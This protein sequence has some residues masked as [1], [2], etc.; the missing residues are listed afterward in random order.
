MK[1]GC[2]LKRSTYIQFEETKIPVDHT[3]Q[4]TNVLCIPPERLVVSEL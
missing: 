4:G 2:V 1:V 3:E